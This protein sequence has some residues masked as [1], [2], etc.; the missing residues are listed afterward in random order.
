MPQSL[1]AG[2][3]VI[4]VESKEEFDI[5][6]GRFNDTYSKRVLKEKASKSK[7]FFFERDGPSEIDITE[8]R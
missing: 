8:W 7:F 5:M 1:C 3:I 4:L 2:D 6:A